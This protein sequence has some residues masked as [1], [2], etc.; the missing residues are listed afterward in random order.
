MN[1]SQFPSQAAVYDLKS[2]SWQ[3][4]TK[5]WLWNLKYIKKITWTKTFLLKQAETPESNK[6]NKNN[7]T[8][9]VN[10]VE[11]R[12]NMTPS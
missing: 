7:Q 5:N 2:L 4:T 1:V 9:M 11:L 6:Q 8:T 3:I 10:N 12:R